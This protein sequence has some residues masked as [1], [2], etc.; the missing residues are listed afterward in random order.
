MEVGDLMLSKVFCFPERGSVGPKGS[1]DGRRY[2]QG[3]TVGLER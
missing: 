3:N 1:A 2:C